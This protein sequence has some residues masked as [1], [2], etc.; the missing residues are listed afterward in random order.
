MTQNLR[1][2]LL[3]PLRLFWLRQAGTATLEFV[4]IFPI[5]MTLFLSSVEVGVLMVRH[6]MLERALDIT[7]RD[8]RLGIVTGITHSEMRTQICSNTFLSPNCETDLMLE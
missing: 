8:I 4:I 6:V 1:T 5:I 3:R 2:C 7:V